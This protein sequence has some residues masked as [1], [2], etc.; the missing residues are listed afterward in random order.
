MRVHERDQNNRVRGRVSMERCLHETLPFFRSRT[1]VCV[2]IKGDK[3]TKKQTKCISMYTIRCL[4]SYDRTYSYVRLQR[5]VCSCIYACV[6]I[7]LKGFLSG[8]EH[9]GGRECYTFS[10]VADVC[11]KSGE[12]VVYEKR[13]KSQCKTIVYFVIRTLYSGQEE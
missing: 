2:R 8:S 9:K 7:C 10:C 6:A 13:G 3:L 5:L 12:S 4:V 11:A 1:C